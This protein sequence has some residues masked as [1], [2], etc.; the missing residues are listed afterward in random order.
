M[1]YNG[2]VII[3]YVLDRL[4]LNENTTP[5]VIKIVVFKTRR[6]VFPPAIVYLAHTWR[7]LSTWALIFRHPN[8][9]PKRPEFFIILN[10]AVDFQCYNL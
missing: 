1:V 10:P 6:S 2:S 5:K 3:F 4:P 8:L 9:K 7:K